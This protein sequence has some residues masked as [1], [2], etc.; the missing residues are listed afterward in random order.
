MDGQLIYGLEEF[1]LNNLQQDTGTGFHEWAIYNL[2][3]AMDVPAPRV[4]FLWVRL[5]GVDKGFYANIETIDDVMLD[6]QGPQ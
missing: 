2:F 3:R 1:T 5:N 4:S 6:Q